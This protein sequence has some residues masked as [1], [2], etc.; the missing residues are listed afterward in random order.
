MKITEA[1]IGMEIVKSS[2]INYDSGEYGTIVEIDEV[3]LRA[4]VCWGYNHT[5]LRVSK[6]ADASIPHTIT[7]AHFLGDYFIKTKYKAI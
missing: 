1:K 2:D 6:L 7:P 3:K 5:W 4:R